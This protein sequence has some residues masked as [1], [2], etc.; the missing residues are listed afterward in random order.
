[1]QYKFFLNVGRRQRICRKMNYCPTDLIFSERVL[2][3]WLI[4]YSIESGSFCSS[5]PLLSIRSCFS[6]FRRSLTQKTSL[7][8]QVEFFRIAPNHKPFSS[9]IGWIRRPLS[10]HFTRST[11]KCCSSSMRFRCTSIVWVFVDVGFGTGDFFSLWG[12]CLFQLIVR[13]LMKL[14]FFDVKVVKACRMITQCVDES[15]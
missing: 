10:R 1:M 4:S 13:R 7:K 2:K 15:T 14:K 12:D 9:L 5:R 3:N 6:S 8:S 11:F